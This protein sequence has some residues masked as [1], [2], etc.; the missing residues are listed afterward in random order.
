M[1]GEFSTSCQILAG[2]PLGGTLIPNWG[3]TTV[4]GMHFKMII[5]FWGVVTPAQ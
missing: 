4:D 1:V 3:T 2:G 5:Y